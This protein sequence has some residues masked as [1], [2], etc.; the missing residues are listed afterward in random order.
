MPYDISL[1]NAIYSDVPAVDLPK[2]GGGTARF[3]DLSGTTA[4]AAD[5][6]SGVKFVDSNGTLTTGTAT[7]MKDFT[8][9]YND[10]SGTTGAITLPQS[11]ANFDY[12]AIYF[13]KT[14][15]DKQ[16]GST[17]IYKPNGQYITLIS[18]N[19]ADA[20]HLWISIRII[21]VNGTSLWNRR[22]GNGDTGNYGGNT[23]NNIAIYRIEAWN[24]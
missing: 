21:G 18:G 1:L 23:T 2:D 24:L 5:V 11:A 8:V 20:S 6:A 12:M 15:D 16:R 4:T 3:Y 13:A 22:S 19:P 17:L 14:D 7:I 10:S 9:L